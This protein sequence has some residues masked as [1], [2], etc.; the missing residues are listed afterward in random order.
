VRALIELGEFR[1]AALWSDKALE[2]FPEDPELLAAK[3]VALARSGDLEEAIALSDAAIEQ[4]GDAPY[5]WLARGDVL[6]ARR[7]KRAEY[8]LEKA[9]ALA[10]GDWVISWLAARVRFYYQQFALAMKLVQTLL[11]SNGGRAVLW[12]E[13]GACQY[14]LGLG[15]CGGAVF[16]PG[17]A[18]ETK[19][20]DAAPH[21]RTKAR[22]VASVCGNVAENVFPMSTA[23]L[24]RLLK[25]ALEHEASDLHLVIGVPAAFR[26]N[27]EIILDNGDV[28]TVQEVNS[29]ADSILNEQQRRKFELDW[30]LC[31]SFRHALAGRLRVTF[32]RRN[33]LQELSLR[34]CGYEIP[35]REILGLPPQVDDLSRKTN[36]LVLITGPTGAGKTTT[37]NYMVNLINQERR[38]KV[39]TIEDPI[40]F[41]HDHQRAIIIQQELLTDVRSFDRALV[42]ALRQDPDVI[43][44]GELRGT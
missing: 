5:V 27:G 9:L 39:V 15:P 21:R 1:E 17:A 37:M 24:D 44:I 19:L 36:G 43:V 22:V 14:E 25:T 42:H 6:L 29:I 34:F 23:H 26:V 41:I 28:L 7:E 40:E 13:L 11:E 16:C 32:Y 30:E 4:R 31:I 20:C 18:A 38:C 12:V 3:A 2:Q 35:R 10:R 33:G 8:C